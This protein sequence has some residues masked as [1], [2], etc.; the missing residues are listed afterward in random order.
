M[1]RSSKP[2]ALICGAVSI[3]ATM[4]FYL[5]IFGNIFTI[6]MRWISLIFLVLAESIG[7]AKALNIKKSIFGVANI[8]T[9]LFHIGIVLV[10]SIMFVNVLPL[11]ISKYILLNILGL[12]VLL[13]VDA[14][15]VYFG[16]HIDDK[17][18]ELAENQAVMDNL[19]TT[20]KSLAIE[21][22][23]SAYGK[24]LDELSELI[25]YSDNSALSNDEVLISEK[26]EE[27][28][29]VLSTDDCE[30]VPRRISDIENIIKLR[31]LKIKA[32]KRGHY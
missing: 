17:N 10:M 20:A 12:C 2:I 16:E 25:R 30:S 21:Y 7:T 24:S 15:I 4:I 8:I 29:E 23:E 1:V 19:Y 18:S 9:S 31:S 6:P 13:A 28:Q 22:S 27:L 14:I 5:L 32:V 26:L 11:F 3:A